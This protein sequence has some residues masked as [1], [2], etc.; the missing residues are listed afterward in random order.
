MTSQKILL[1]NQV[2]VTPREFRMDFCE[3]SVV[4]CVSL[5]N[6]KY[7]HQDGKLLYSFSMKLV[8]DNNCHVST[9]LI[10]HISI[11]VYRLF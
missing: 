7:L 4:N 11:S 9:L 1:T 3:W 8:I 2:G 6:L 5:W 10:Q